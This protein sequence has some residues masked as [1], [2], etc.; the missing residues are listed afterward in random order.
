MAGKRS[1]DRQA[2]G[3]RGVARPYFPEPPD[4]PDLIGKLY[5]GTMVLMS[6][7]WITV[8]GE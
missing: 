3:R 8:P 4:R 5:P 2:Q 7:S 6:C 1:V